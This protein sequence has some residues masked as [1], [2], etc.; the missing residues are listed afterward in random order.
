MTESNIRRF[1]RSGYIC[2]FTSFGRIHHNTRSRRVA[3][4]DI[5]IAIY[6]CYQAVGSI[7]RS[8]IDQHFAKSRRTIGLE[9]I[10][11]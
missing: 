3:H 6:I 8:I 5:K 11:Q 10:S 4:C 9:I 1:F 7:L 2:Q